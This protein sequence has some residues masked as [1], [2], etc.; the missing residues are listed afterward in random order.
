[1]AFK[2]KPKLRF[3]VRKYLYHLATLRL[4]RNPLAPKSFPQFDPSFE[5]FRN[6]GPKT[7]RRSSSFIT[8]TYWNPRALQ[9]LAQLGFETFLMGCLFLSTSLH[10]RPN[11][12]QRSGCIAFNIHISWSSL[13]CFFRMEICPKFEDKNFR[14]IVL[15]ILRKNCS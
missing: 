12:T 6:K 3:L 10:N 4:T 5:K 14:V 15:G 13:V 9:T 11:V 2:N 8:T 7:R 1:M